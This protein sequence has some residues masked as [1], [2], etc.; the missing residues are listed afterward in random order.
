LYNR[1]AIGAG[2]EVEIGIRKEN[3]IGIEKKRKRKVLP[4]EVNTRSNTRSERA[5]IIY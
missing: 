3:T 2:M 4:L 1:P 5:Y